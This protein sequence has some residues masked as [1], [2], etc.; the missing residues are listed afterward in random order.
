MKHEFSRRRLLQGG[1][2]GV[3][4]SLI[5]F[6]EWFARYGQARAQG[7]LVRYSIK[8]AA[9]A[10]M[11]AK[12]NSAVGTMMQRGKG[13][14]C[15][16]I[17]QWY[18]HQIR[19]DLGKTAEIGTL[20]AG[21]RPLATDMWNTCQAHSGRP[22][23]YFLPWHR[24]YVYFLERIV[25]QACGD[26]G[27]TLPYW[28]YMDSTQRPIPAAFRTPTSSPLFRPDRNNGTGGSANVN[29]GQAID[30]GQ[31]AGTLNL[32][33]MDEAD[34]LPSATSDG[35]NAMINQNPHGIVHTL[36]GNTKGMGT[37]PWAG[38]DPVFWAH[39]CNIDRLWASWNG[40][41]RSNPTTADWRDKTFV[42]ADENCNRVVAKVSDFE[43]I[44]QLGYAYDQVA[45]AR[46]PPRFRQLRLIA[47]FRDPR[48]DPGPLRIRLGD[49]AVTVQ[50]VA[51]RGSAALS[52][53]MR[54]LG[55][56]PRA[57]LTLR[58]LQAGAAPG[59]LYHVYLNLP[60][61][62]SAAVA[63]R[64]YVGA[65]TFFD[66]VVPGRAQMEGMD[67]A[68]MGEGPSF[69]FD[70]TP[71]VRRLAGAG[72]LDVTL[73]PQGRPVAGANPVIGN[74]ELAAE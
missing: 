21:Q 22:L 8:T 49:R 62:A 11:L 4:A 1:F 10:A 23:R 63:Q 42:F 74:I 35:F 46:V 7:P 64:H 53:S 39:H 48:P 6:P 34:Y 69:S 27:F 3:A 68:G 16:W 73:V 51:P 71:M 13:D 56:T 33:C 12:Y 26:P 17:F 72:R 9:G 52:S 5:P 60:A 43:S 57:R 41:G 66:A 54:A 32:A 70:V 45:P 44:G 47:A 20:P 38:N 28:D 31:P 40:G 36:I 19:D 24:M 67:H 55:S 61:R 25:R 30:L 18:T 15:S 29:G 2:S 58:N 14:P 65:I 50:L 59:I 37:V